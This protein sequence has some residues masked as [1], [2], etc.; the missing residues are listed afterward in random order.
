MPD[1]TIQNLTMTDQLLEAF[2]CRLTDDSYHTFHLCDL[3]FRTT[4][5]R[6]CACVRVIGLTANLIANERQD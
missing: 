2:G 6:V 1:L 5:G 4:A 3:T